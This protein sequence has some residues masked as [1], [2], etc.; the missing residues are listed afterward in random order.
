MCVEDSCGDVVGPF[1]VVKEIDDSVAKVF[2]F[3]VVAN[4]ADALVV[5]L[6]CFFAFFISCVVTVP[7]IDDNCRGVGIKGDGVDFFFFE[8]GGEF[9]FE[10][11]VD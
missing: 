8:G 1:G 10:R 2:I 7:G 3:E 11:L 9:V 5:D 6:G 4:A